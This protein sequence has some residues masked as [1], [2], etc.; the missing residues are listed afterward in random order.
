[1]ARSLHPSA[2]R[3]AADLEA[4]ADP[5]KSFVIAGGR[6]SFSCGTNNARLFGVSASCTSG[7]AEAIRA[8]IRAVRRKAGAA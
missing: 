8:W 2:E 3:L 6:L 5:V 7:E 4:S 1:M